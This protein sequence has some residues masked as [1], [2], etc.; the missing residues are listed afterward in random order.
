MKLEHIGDKMKEIVIKSIQ[1]NSKNT[2]IYV[3]LSYSDN[4]GELMAFIEHGDIL[5]PIL[6][7][8][9]SNH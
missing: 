9:I 5:N 8:R 1:E 7:A 6:E 3:N 2:D 4:D